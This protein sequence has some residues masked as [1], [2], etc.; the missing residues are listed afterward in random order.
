MTD[1]WHHFDPY[2]DDVHGRYDPDTT[3]W[4]GGRRGGK[5]AA[6]QWARDMWGDWQSIPHVIFRLP[7]ARFD[8][9]PTCY[10]RLKLFATDDE[11]HNIRLRLHALISTAPPIIGPCWIE[12]PSKAEGCRCWRGL[13]DAEAAEMRED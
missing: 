6:L 10:Y 1:T 3:I 4:V 9:C 7:G 2:E 12:G 13:T 8:V 5:R 11:P